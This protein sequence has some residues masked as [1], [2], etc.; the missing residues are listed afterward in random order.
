[1]IK[2]AAFA[3]LLIAVSLG[4]YSTIL[5][6]KIATLAEKNSE[7]SQ[8]LRIQSDMQIRANAIDTQRTKELVDAKNKISALQH[9]VDS[10]ARRLQLNAI[11]PKS[12]DTTSASLADAAS[13]RLTPAAQR[14]YWTLRERIETAKAQ[15]SGLQD[16]VRDVCSQN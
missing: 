5:H 6:K 10:G 12:P 16:Y 13:P 11:C 2:S 7:M 3:A 15:I 1:M 4:W 14:D 8:S 9:D